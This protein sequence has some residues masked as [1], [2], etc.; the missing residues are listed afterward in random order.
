MTKA[1]R[2][3]SGA[4]QKKFFRDLFGSID[5]LSRET[6]AALSSACESRIAQVRVRLP[7]IEREKKPTPEAAGERG[8]KT[9]RPES[10]T[11]EQQTSG[12]TFDPFAFSVVVAVTKE[13]R[14]GLA[15]RLLEIPSAGDLRALAKAQHVALPEGELTDGELRD[16]I[17]EGALQRIANRKAAAS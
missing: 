8:R 9:A 6:T 14:E 17:V 4:S 5:G 16:A 12:Q 7:A 13:G 1:T 11:E 3:L 2:T 15:K 10:A